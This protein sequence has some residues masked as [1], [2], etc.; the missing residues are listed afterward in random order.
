LD[1]AGAFGY[2]AQGRPHGGLFW[3]GR[4]NNRTEQARGP[5]FNPDEMANTDTAALA[6]RLRA[7]PYAAD[8]RAA[9]GLPAAATDAQL[10]DAAISA[11]VRY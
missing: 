9:A 4:A 8:L 6:A 5:L 11:L 1:Q 10:V 7:L 3:D 2:D